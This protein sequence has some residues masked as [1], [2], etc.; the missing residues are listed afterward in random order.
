MVAPNVTAGK[1]GNLAALA[2]SAC[3]AWYGFWLLWLSAHAV[4]GVDPGSVSPLLLQGSGVDTD[5][6]PAPHMGLFI[7]KYVLDACYV[8][9]ISLWSRGA[10]RVATFECVSVFTD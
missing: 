9:K 6:I 8:L 4:L 2:L 1:D 5:A 10:S 7:N 3:C